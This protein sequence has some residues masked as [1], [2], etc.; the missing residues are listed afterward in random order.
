MM[1]HDHKTEEG[2][3]RLGQLLGQVCRLAGHMM[4]KH[5]KSIG[6]HKGQGFALVHLWHHDGMA[7]R[8]LAE[9]MHLRPASVTN[10]LQ[11]MERD[12]LILRDRDPEDQRIVRVFL[13][14]QAKRMREEARKAIHGM[15]TE[16]AE[17]YTK[18][19]CATLHRL[20]GK[21]HDHLAPAGSDI[22]HHP[23]FFE[24]GEAA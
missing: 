13:T 24:P 5:M 2:E 15:E 1:L 14:Q 8:D 21:L 6:L 19:E 20:L 23:R 7:Q 17:I 10:M 22:G 9:A 4:R 3:M 12:G 16:L 18:E 11:R